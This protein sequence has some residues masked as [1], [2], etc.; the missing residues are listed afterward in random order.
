[1]M[2]AALMAMSALAIDAMLPA[3]PAIGDSLGVGN[4]NRNQLIVLGFM[5]GFGSAQIFYGPLADRFGRKPVLLAGI[6]AYTLLSLACG[7]AAGFE[8]L[9]AARMLQGGAAAV[10][11]VIVVAMV[12]D[13]FEGPAMASTMSLLFMIFMLVP[14]LA[15][16]MGQLILAYAGWRVIFFL[17]A[18]Y[19]L[20]MLCWV[21]ARLPETLHP[22]HR[23]ALNWRVLGAGLA[24]TLGDRQSLGYTLAAAVLFGGFLAYLASIQQI[25][26]GLGHA[27]EIGLVFAA[28]AVPMAFGAFANSRL[29]ARVGVRPM[30]NGALIGFALIA[31]IHALT[32][33]LFGE[34]LMLFTVLIGLAMLCFALASSN[35][36]TLA[37]ANMGPLAGTASSVQGVMT[38]VGA[39]LIGLFIGQKY[40]GSA[41]PVLIGMATCSAAAVL[42][43]VVV[44]RGRLFAKAPPG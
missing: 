26:A 35:L 20:V 40:D 15:P 44:E 43:V 37:M 39:T 1:M 38:T 6:T 13:M 34:S 27:D 30:G 5:F 10:A 3:L 18:G 2:L 16:A 12:R 21:L 14:I 11:R 4:P 17:L 42:I 29:V 19:G 9:V 36:S 25:L 24:A 32:A 33:E 23:R 28:V 22:E 7:I 41:M 8:L 31:G